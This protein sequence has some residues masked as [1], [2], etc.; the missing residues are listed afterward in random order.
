MLS[1]KFAMVVGVNMD[2]LVP[3]MEY[4]TSD[5]SIILALGTTPHPIDF[6]LSRNTPQEHRVALAALVVDTDSYC[7][8]VGMDFIRAI[9][10]AYD[11]Y[12]A[13]FKYKFP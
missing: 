4:N 1:K 8:L 12:T 11:S 9:R 5:G 6:V 2:I 13:M 3:G 10:G 7:M